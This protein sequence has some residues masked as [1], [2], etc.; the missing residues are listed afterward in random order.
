MKLLFI[1]FTC[2]IFLVCAG[3][4]TARD[5]SYV[6]ATPFAALGDTFVAPFTFA[7]HGYPLLFSYGDAHLSEVREINKYKAT[8]PL[9]ELTAGV[10]Y[11]PG[12]FCWPLYHITPDSYYPMTRGCLAA[13]RTEE[14]E[15][16]KQ[17]HEAARETRATERHVPDHA[18]YDEFREW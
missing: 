14:A 8:L 16:K 3:C 5:A 9:S 7:G 11:V 10:F 6:V 18:A 4:S 17:T 13:L 2:S 1:I 12:A 15:E